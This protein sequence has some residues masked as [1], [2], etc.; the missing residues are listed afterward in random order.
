MHQ[1][2]FAHHPH[3][4]T[5]LLAEQ[6]HTRVV[7]G[8]EERQ[9]ALV[10]QVH[11][12]AGVRREQFANRRGE[13]GGMLITALNLGEV[14]ARMALGLTTLRPE[15]KAAPASNEGEAAAIALGKIGAIITHGTGV[16]AAFR[17]RMPTYA[18]ATVMNEYGPTKAAIN[19]INEHRA[20]YVDMLVNEGRAAL[21]DGTRQ[22]QGIFR[23]AV[24]L[25][26]IRQGQ[27]GIGSTD[28][29]KRYMKED[30]YWN[31]YL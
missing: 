7:A 31:R 9:T 24:R 16:D 2:A 3:M 11:A 29:I 10:E 17:D 20:E 8:N 5:Q 28:A 13:I 25:L 30:P 15:V 23:M 26:K 4:A 21:K 1:Q 27:R 19:S 12:L 6:V 14:T 18:T 22:Q